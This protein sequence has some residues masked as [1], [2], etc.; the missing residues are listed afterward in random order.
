LLALTREELAIEIIERVFAPKGLHDSARGFNPG[1]R[2]KPH[3]A[4]T[5]R[6]SVTP[7]RKTPGAPGLEVLKGRQIDWPNNAKKTMNA[8]SVSART[9]ASDSSRF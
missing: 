6:Y 3:R 5:R 1:N 8:A 9:S 4:L 7:S 2:P